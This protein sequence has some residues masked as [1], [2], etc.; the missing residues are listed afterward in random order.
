[1]RLWGAHPTYAPPY[2]PPPPPC[3]LTLRPANDALKN[4]TD[5]TDASLRALV[6]DASKLKST[7]T[8]HVVPGAT[9][10][11]ARIK[12]LVAKEPTKERK[13]KTLQGETLIA[14]VDGNTLLINGAGCS[15]G[16][17]GVKGAAHCSLP[18]SPAVR[19]CA[20]HI[21][22]HVCNSQTSLHAV[23]PLQACP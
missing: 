5:S 18:C 15:Q 1:M 23:H 17:A 22:R 11:A 8:Y 19:A 20:V 10:S 14:T 4:L 12:D 13:F 6:D 2:H 16:V 21:V 9:L 7:L 3:W